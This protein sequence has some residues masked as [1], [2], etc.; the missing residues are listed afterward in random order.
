MS[1]QTPNDFERVEDG[2]QVFYS[3]FSQYD[4]EV[5]HMDAAQL[6]ALADWLASERDTIVHDARTQEGR[7]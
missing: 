5:L 4:K 6:L 3:L 7:G 2:E 1:K